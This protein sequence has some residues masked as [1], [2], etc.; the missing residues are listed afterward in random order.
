MKIGYTGILY[1]RISLTINSRS[2]KSGKGKPTLLVQ[3]TFNRKRGIK[4]IIINQT[5]F[6]FY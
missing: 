2:H 1:M 4:S 5:F 6:V 3:T